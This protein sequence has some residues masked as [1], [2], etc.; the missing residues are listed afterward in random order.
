[1]CYV[2]R[3]LGFVMISVITAVFVSLKTVS[4]EYK[5]HS[6]ISTDV[7]LFTLQTS[8]CSFTKQDLILT[9]VACITTRDA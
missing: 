1:M 2:S 7:S 3:S 8:L 4:A 9:R 6:L 5:L